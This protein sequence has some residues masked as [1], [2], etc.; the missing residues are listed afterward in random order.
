VTVAFV[1]LGSNLQDPRRQIEAAF[2]ELDAL[3][4]SRL[5]KRSSLYRSAPVGY[6]GQPDFVNAVARL[7]TGLSAERLLSELQAIELT[8]GREKSFP[9][10]PRTLDLDLLLFGD[11]TFSNEKLTVPHPRMHERAFVLRP[12]T[13]IESD[14]VIPGRGPVAEYIEKTKGQEAERIP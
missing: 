13:E 5:V 3:P 7:E 12:L 14:L 10:A 4:H 6:A 11:S 1:G 2:A 8:H 9:N